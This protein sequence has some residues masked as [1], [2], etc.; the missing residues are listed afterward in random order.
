MNAYDDNMYL[1][2]FDKIGIVSLEFFHCEGGFWSDIND[3]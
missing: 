2:T 3:F 1:K